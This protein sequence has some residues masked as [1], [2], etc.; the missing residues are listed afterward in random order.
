MTAPSLHIASIAVFMIAIIP[1]M[2]LSA[3]PVDADVPP[4]Y[5]VVA[6]EYSVPAVLLYSMALTESN[7]PSTVAFLPWPWTVNDA[8]KGLF[9]KTRQEAYDYLSQVLKSGRKNFDVG[10]VQVNWYWNGHVFP[11]LWSSLDPYTNLRAGAKILR[12]HY[13]RLGS[14]EEAVGAYHSPGNSARAYAYR[15]RVR[16]NLATVLQSGA[17]AS[18]G[19]RF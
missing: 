6:D 15:E 17:I 14:Y 11:S 4:A 5:Q 1:S 9:F 12:G 3:N 13:R 10:L 18:Q 16:G 2:V 7:D 19:S 8:G